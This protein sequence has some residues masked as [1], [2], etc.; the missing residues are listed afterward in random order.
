MQNVNSWR[1]VAAA[2]GRADR[3]AAE[4]GVRRA[5]RTAGLAEPDRQGRIAPASRTAGFWSP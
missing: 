4:A 1:S 3:A 2:T 5:Y